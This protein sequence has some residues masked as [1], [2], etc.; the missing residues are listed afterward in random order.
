MAVAGVAS[1]S[2]KVC[3]D[4]NV[5]SVG[6]SEVKYTVGANRQ[7]KQKAGG[8][9]CGREQGWRRCLIQ[10]SVVVLFGA[11]GTL[12]RNNP[13]AVFEGCCCD[14]EHTCWGRVSVLVLRIFLENSSLGMLPL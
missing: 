6:E 10:P 14:D 1:F 7:P 12:V 9:R 8:E 5:F 11:F 13:H 3:P 2:N 4:W